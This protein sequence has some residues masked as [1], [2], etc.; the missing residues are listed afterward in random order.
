MLDFYDASLVQQIATN[1]FYGWGY[2]FYKAE[3]QLRADDQLVRAKCVFLLNE[4]ASS[5]G[6]AESTFRRERLPAPTRARPY[7]DAEAVAS[8]GKLERLHAELLAL[9]ARIQNLPVPASDLI[10]KRYR[11]EGTTLLAL[12]DRDAQ[13]VGRCDLLRSALAGKDATWLVGN[14]TEFLPGIGAIEAALR[15]REQLLLGF[16]SS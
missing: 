16:P 5:V 10:F 1:L 8:A 13:L 6:T 7:P 14:L 9:A 11:E 12:L 2:N 15:G 4:T 3:N